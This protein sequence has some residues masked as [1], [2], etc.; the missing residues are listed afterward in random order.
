MVRRTL[1]WGQRFLAGFL[2]SSDKSLATG[3]VLALIAWSVTR[4][5]DGVTTTGT[6]EYD[7]TISPTKLAEGQPGSLILV[8]LSNLSGDTL[9]TNLEATLSDPSG[10]IRFSTNPKDRGCAFEPPA[11][12]ENPTCDPHVTGFAFTAPML[13]PGTYATFGIK[14]TVAAGAD[15]KPV[16]RIKPDGSTKV[17]LVEAGLET[18]IA[19]HQT[20]LL[21]GLLL[22]TLVLFLLS[23]AAG[24]PKVA[25]KA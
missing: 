6:L 16:L 5:V 11:W 13:V 19:R 1:S 12:G 3:I 20:G 22:V 7:T 10:K 15:V 2:S 8:K 18:Y 14:Y 23:V 21:A 17:R 4:L 25:P 9:L 24:V